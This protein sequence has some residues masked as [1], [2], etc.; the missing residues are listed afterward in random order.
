MR[1]TAATTAAK[2]KTKTHS[3][4]LSLSLS[5]SPHLLL[6][7]SSSKPLRW[8]RARRPPPPLRP[9]LA[10][11][12]LRPRGRPDRRALPQ[13][14]LA[15]DDFGRGRV[16][17]E[18]GLERKL[19]Q[20]RRRDLSFEHY[21]HRPYRGRQER[22]EPDGPRARLRPQHPRQRSGA[23]DEQVEGQRGEPGRRRVRVRGGLAEAVRDVHGPAEGDQGESVERGLEGG[24]GEGR[25][26]EFWGGLCVSR[27][28]R[29][30]KR[31]S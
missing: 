19:V 17:G 18:A 5:F 31:G 29:K 8:R 23:Q 15:G 12:P 1:A 25:E 3:L 2:N 27:F 30:S 4:S 13:A 21:P 11:G 28:G 9:L 10:Q 6:S 14:G 24:C 7:S 20:R 16:H 22:L 26:G